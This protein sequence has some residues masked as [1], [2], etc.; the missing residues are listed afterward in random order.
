LR[1]PLGEVCY[2]LFLQSGCGE[3]RKALTSGD[4]ARHARLKALKNPTPWRCGAHAATL[5][6]GLSTARRDSRHRA[7]FQV[8]QR[9]TA[10]EIAVRSIG[11]TVHI[12]SLKA[13]S[14]R[15]PEYSHRHWWCIL[16]GGTHWLVVALR[17]ST[18]CRGLGYKL[19]ISVTKRVLYILFRECQAQICRIVMRYVA[20]LLWRVLAATAGALFGGQ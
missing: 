20:T 5:C 10:S 15:Q 8:I 1:I 12:T 17:R 11:L 13:H 6:V 19:V 3:C 2:L 14:E 4:E 9:D 16:P 7:T 18:V